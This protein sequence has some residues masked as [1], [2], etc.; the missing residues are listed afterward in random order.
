LL[1]EPLGDS[2]DEALALEPDSGEETGLVSVV[3][4]LNVVAAAE[5]AKKKGKGKT[6]VTVLCD[7]AYR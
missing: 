5:L 7:G 2:V 1:L 3:R 6:I 4:A